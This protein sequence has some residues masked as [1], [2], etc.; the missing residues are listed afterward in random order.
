MLLIHEVEQIKEEIFSVK[1]N[2][3]ELDYIEINIRLTKEDYMGY[4]Q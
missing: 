1:D 3:Y 2:Y 4:Q